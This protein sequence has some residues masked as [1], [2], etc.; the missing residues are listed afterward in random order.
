MDLDTAADRKKET[1]WKYNTVI[2]HLRDFEVLRLI[3]EIRYLQ[4]KITE[5]YD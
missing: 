1:S 5:R 3:P 2:V 4:S